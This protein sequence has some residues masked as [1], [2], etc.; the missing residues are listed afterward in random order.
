MALSRPNATESGARMRPV[1]VRRL[2]GL[3][4]VAS[5]AASEPAVAK[6]YLLPDGPLSTRG[7]QIVDAKGD[8]VRILSVGVFTNVSDRVQAIVDAGFNTIRVE[9]GNRSLRTRLGYLDSIVAAADRVGLK[10][11]LDDHFNEGLNA[12]CFAQQANGLWYDSGG[13]SDNTD[14]CRTRG[15][16]TDQRFVEDW[17]MVARHFRGE[18][19]VIGYDLFNEPLAY[20][21]GMSTWEPGDSNPA[22]NIRYMYERTGD[23]ILAIDPTKLIICE[24][25]Q[26]VHSFV[27]PNLPAPWG[28]LSLARRYPVNL[29]VSDKLVYSVHD[30]PYE[31]SGY[32]PDSGPL[33]VARMNKIWGYLVTDSIAPVWIGEMG[34]NMASP[35]DAAWARTL[36]DYAN[37]ASGALGGPVFSSGQQG[38]GIN[39]WW[40]GYDAHSGNQPSGIFDAH[41]SVNRKQQI[42][43]RR[44]S[45][46]VD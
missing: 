36:I 14:G 22:H 11:I 28:D 8:A 40:A 34:A 33:K 31:I 37:G 19:A 35:D 5:L 10:V 15:T 6:T 12:P 43:Y 1:A 42:V 30:Y 24:G 16:V 2:I 7:N 20:N 18:S 27:D 45:Y 26:S 46:R 29:K 39:W 9:W 21:S 41:G 13:G 4:I 32:S 17:Q 3:L 25:P 38:V 44:F 23:A